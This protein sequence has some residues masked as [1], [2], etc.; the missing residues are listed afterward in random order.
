[1]LYFT[2]TREIIDVKS[3]ASKLLTGNVGYLRIKA[4]QQGTHTELLEHV[5][6]LRRAASGNVR[7]WLLDLRNN[8]GGLVDEATAVADELLPGGGGCTRRRRGGAGE[9][10]RAQHGGARHP[11]R[12]V[13]RSS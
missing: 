2:L 9:E 4:F 10:A 11:R 1:L 12:L 7:G 3:V 5:A 6:A 13:A 8:P